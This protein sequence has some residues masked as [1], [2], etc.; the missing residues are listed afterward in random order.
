MLHSQVNYM[1]R[2]DTN[3][4]M[5][6][7]MQIHLF[8]KLDI[9]NIPQSLEKKTIRKR[10]NKSYQSVIIPKIFYTLTIS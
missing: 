3:K 1:T 2:A 8:N 4:I 6:F 5:I 7:K 10:E 9:H